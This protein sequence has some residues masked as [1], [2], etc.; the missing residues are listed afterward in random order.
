MFH[1][2]PGPGRTIS[3]RS[4]VAT[5][6]SPDSAGDE[7]TLAAASAD[8]GPPI[9]AAAATRRWS[10]ASL[11]AVLF[12]MAVVTAACQKGGEGGGGGHGGPGGP[13]GAMPALPVSVVKVE[14][15]SL[16]LTVRSPGQAEGSR[17]VEVRA[18]VGGI[19]ERK[20][21]EEGD[22]LKADA[23]MYQIDKAPLEIAL[24]QARAQLAQAQA[25]L[26]EAR[27]EENRL[28]PL[29]ARRAVS[30]REY[31]T[32]VATRR[33]AEA[34]RAATQSQVRDA[35]LNLS[36]STVRAPINGV[37]GRSLKSEGS[38]VTVGNDGSLLTTISTLDPIWVRFGLSEADNQRLRSGTIGSVRIVD[39]A[40]Q[41]LVGGGEINFSS[42]TIDR[43]L[44]TLQLRATFPN[45]ERRVLPG[46]FV[47]VEVRVTGREAWKVPQQAVIQTDK[48][49]MVWVVGDDSKVA[50]RSIKV[51]EWV[52]QDWVVTEGLKDGDQVIA[53]NLFKIRPGAPVAP[54][55][56]GQGPG[57]P[58]GGTSGGAPG[59]AAGDSASSRA[60]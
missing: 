9:R 59:G 25:R 3:G 32:A 1:M 55:A 16:P 58:A 7:P 14:R 26:D 40:G 48:G 23:P 28:K 51:A 56:L 41:E 38:L 6:V 49:R 2:P 31:D 35:E 17:E 8:T 27:R 52:G 24:S 36:Y 13:G 30:Q 44:G 47:Q 19:L 45:P 39:S 46:Q 42:T 11:T 15:Q 50:S 33:T 54:H 22:V 12:A 60:N 21:F 53:D 43:T 10:K 34:S 4:P 57:G 29:A 5:A 18:R 20:L 37:S